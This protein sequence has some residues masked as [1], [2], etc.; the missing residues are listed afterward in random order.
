MG[1]TA[2]SLRLDSPN[3]LAFLTQNLFIEIAS[4]THNEPTLRYGTV[5]NT[6]CQNLLQIS[7]PPNPVYARKRPK[8]CKLDAV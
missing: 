1:C 3:Y 2:C 4:R 6:K 5:T 7:L 8:I